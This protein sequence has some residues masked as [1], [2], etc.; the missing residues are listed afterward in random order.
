MVIK[1]YKIILK[2]KK[3]IK[4]TTNMATQKITFTIKNINESGPLEVSIEKTELIT[5]EG[6]KEV[7]KIFFCASPDERKDIKNTLESKNSDGTENKTFELEYDDED[8]E[9]EKKEDLFMC[10]KVS[11]GPA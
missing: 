4:I 3:L 5:K 10:G 6:N 11:S 2:G 9:V 1:L 7:E 8:L